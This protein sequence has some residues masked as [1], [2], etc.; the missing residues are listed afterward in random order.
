MFGFLFDFCV[1]I[2]LSIKSY[3]HFYTPIEQE[4]QQFFSVFLCFFSECSAGQCQ[5]RGSRFAESVVLACFSVQVAWDEW[6]TDLDE[7][8][9][10][11]TL[12]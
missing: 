4:C 7:R 5:I 1:F 3:F 10:L 6:L 9:T 2:G 11:C 8:S 12:G